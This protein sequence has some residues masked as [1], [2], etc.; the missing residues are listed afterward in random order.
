[1]GLSYSD[2]SEISF[3]IT[4][5]LVTETPVT[6][7]FTL[8]FV[9]GDLTEILHPVDFPT[10]VEDGILTFSTSQFECDYQ[11]CCQDITFT[12]SGEVISEGEF[13]KS[14]TS[15]QTVS[16]KATNSHGFVKTSDIQ[17]IVPMEIDPFYYPLYVS[18]I[19]NVVVDPSFDA[20][21]LKFL[22]EF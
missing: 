4:S 19:E 10:Q 5:T 14:Y 21:S 22:P 3:T 13:T 8:N 18:D 9:C 2:E 1:M 11:I 20:D 7:D 17:I 12:V 6:A 15:N 16:V